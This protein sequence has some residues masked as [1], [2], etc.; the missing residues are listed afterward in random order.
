MPQ[1][2]VEGGFSLPCKSSFINSLNKK[3]AFTSIKVS[4]G[5]RDTAQQWGVRLALVWPWV[6]SPAPTTQKEDEK[7]SLITVMSNS[8][9]SPA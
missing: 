2:L 7:V 8:Y 6:Q 1:N 4:L 5:A 3:E 9:G